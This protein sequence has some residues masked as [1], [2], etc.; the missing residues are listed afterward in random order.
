MPGARTDGH[1]LGLAVEGGAMRGVISAAMLVALSDT[2][3]RPCFDLIVGT[4]AGAINAAYFLTEHGWEALSVYFQELLSPQF[5]S[6]SRLASRRPVMSLDFLVNSVLSGS[7]PM[8]WQAI[9]ASPV[10]LHIVVGSLNTLSPLLLSGLRSPA[11]LAAALRATACLPLL[12]GDP[13]PWGD[14]L[15]VD[16]GALDGHPAR[17]AERLG[18]THMLALS[19][20][21]ARRSSR[22][23]LSVERLV[24]RRLERLRE[25]LGAAYLNKLGSYGADKAFLA[26]ASAGKQGGVPML[27]IAPAE[28]AASPSRFERHPDILMAAAIAGYEAAAT[29]I[30]GRR[31]RASLRVVAHPSTPLQP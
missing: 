6:L 19:T 5:V 20:R 26:D 28:D 2:G 21:P 7:R 23:P 15:L 14:D 17:H 24:A 1:C 13:I 29:A 4:S 30:T 8:D 27:E 31:T 10:P 18:C 3:C 9:L 25:G 12:A 22:T 11:Q 16:G